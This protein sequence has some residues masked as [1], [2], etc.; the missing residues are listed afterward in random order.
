MWG[1]ES[2]C[3]KVKGHVLDLIGIKR[4]SSFNPIELFLSNGLERINSNFHEK[5][6]RV[7]KWNVFV[8]CGKIKCCN[9]HTKMKLEFRKKVC[10]PKH[11]LVE[12]FS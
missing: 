3:E 12:F 2:S 7:R 1:V 5:V 9:A 11:V 8:D 6:E 4:T 10:K